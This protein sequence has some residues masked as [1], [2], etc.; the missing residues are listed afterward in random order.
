[1]CLKN[2][3]TFARDSPY[4]ISAVFSHKLLFQERIQL[5]QKYTMSMDPS[6]LIDHTEI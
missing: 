4:V 5:I 3:N 1:M 6:R 2:Q